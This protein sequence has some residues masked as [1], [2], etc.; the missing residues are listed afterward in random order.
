MSIAKLLLKQILIAIQTTISYNNNNNNTT[1][2]PTTKHSTITKMTTI[3]ITTTITTTAKE[4]ISLPMTSSMTKT[5]QNVK[6]IF[7]KRNVYKFTYC[8]KNI[9]NYYYNYCSTSNVILLLDIFD[10]SVILL[11]RWWDRMLIINNNKKK[12]NKLKY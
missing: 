3:T 6:H 12:A 10:L 8:L 11:I 7:V 4:A 1:I 9:L 5:L 2:M